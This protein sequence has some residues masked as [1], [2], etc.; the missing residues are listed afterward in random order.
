MDKVIILSEK[1]ELSDIDILA[2]TKHQTKIITYD[3]LHNIFDI[4]EILEPYGSAVI[5][6]TTKENFNHWVTLF[7]VNDTTL[8]FFDPYGL[9]VDEELN[10]EIKENLRPLDDD[11]IPH[12]SDI[13]NNS[14]YKLIYNNFRLQKLLKDHNTCGR[15][16][17]VR[18]RFKY[19]PLKY[20]IDLFKKNGDYI[21][22][23]LTLL[24]SNI[25][26]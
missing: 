1:V 18:L 24:F 17:A 11:R 3:K 4:E 6:Y 21:V 16:C 23:S 12:L 25:I 20:F 7:K 22:S 14:N 26:L 8:E 13:L 2:I 9:K 19:I 10:L 5:L 15:W